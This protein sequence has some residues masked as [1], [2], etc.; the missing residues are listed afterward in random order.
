MHF[1]PQKLESD[2]YLLHSVFLVQVISERENKYEKI[3]IELGKSLS[4]VERIKLFYSSKYLFRWVFIY[5]L[6][7]LSFRVF[8]KSLWNSLEII[9]WEL[10]IPY[11]M[12]WALCPCGHGV[13][14]SNSGSDIILQQRS[15]LV[16]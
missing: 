7:S 3:K 11:F 4:L 6:L 2:L 16:I 15:Y 13:L 12:V 8:I 14:V 5:C 9:L 10:I 1:Q